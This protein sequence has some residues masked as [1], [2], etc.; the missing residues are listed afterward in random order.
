MGLLLWYLKCRFPS[1]VILFPILS[2][3]YYLS[4]WGILISFFLLSQTGMSQTAY[5][6]PKRSHIDTTYMFGTSLGNCLPLLVLLER[7][8]KCTVLLHL[9]HLWPKTI[10][11]CLVLGAILVVSDIPLALVYPIIPHVNHIRLV[12]IHMY[13]VPFIFC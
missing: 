12:N 8:F 5:G 4:C 2:T 1:S 10:F 7:F 13:Q 9:S 6:W 3:V 11:H